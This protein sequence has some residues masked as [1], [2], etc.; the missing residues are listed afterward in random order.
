MN[1]E[2]TFEN[3][4]NVQLEHIE[5]WSKLLNTET[6]LKLLSEVIARNNKGYNSPYEVCRGT[7]ISNI[8]QNFNN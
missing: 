7:D 8:I 5:K 4:F 3:A 6:Y 2:F 1:Q